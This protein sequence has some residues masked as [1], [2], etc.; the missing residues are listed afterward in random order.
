[1]PLLDKVEGNLKADFDV[2]EMNKLLKVYIDHEIRSGVEIGLQQ[3][4]QEIAS[5]DSKMTKLKQDTEKEPND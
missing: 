5:V 4:K 1:M 3:V 2:S